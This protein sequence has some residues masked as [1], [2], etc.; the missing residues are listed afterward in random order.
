ML[1]FY[2]ENL[3]D[4]RKPPDFAILGD[5]NFTSNS[6]V[7]N[8]H[9]LRAQKAKNIVG[10][11]KSAVIADIFLLRYIIPKGR[12]FSEWGITALKAQFQRLDMTRPAES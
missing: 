1:D 8:G 5:Y 7:T 10:I 11:P 12:H 3:S 9:I 4:E 6:H 2:G